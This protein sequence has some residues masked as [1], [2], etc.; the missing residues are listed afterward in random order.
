[1]GAFYAAPILGIV[2]VWLSDDLWKFDQTWISA[3]FLAYIALI[4]LSFTVQVPTMRKLRAHAIS[5]SR[6]DPPIVGT[7][8]KPRLSTLQ[9]IKDLSPSLG[10]AQRVLMQVEGITLDEAYEVICEASDV[11]GHTELEI[12]EEI[13][14]T[15]QRPDLAVQATRRGVSSPEVEALVRR[16]TVVGGLV[17]IIWAVVLCL[18]VFKPGV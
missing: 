8:E 16:A 2:L 11:T 3:S 13:L 10:R 4:V 9:G 14:A 1:M 5:T 15:G 17:N 12:S 18:M 7:S 6:S